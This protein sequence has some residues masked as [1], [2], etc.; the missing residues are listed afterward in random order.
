ML[1][2]VI[3]VIILLLFLL[4]SQELIHMFVTVGSLI[5]ISKSDADDGISLAF[6]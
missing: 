6:S 1:V 5:N 2:A 4:T 3:N